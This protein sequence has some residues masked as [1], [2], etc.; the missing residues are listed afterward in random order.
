MRRIWRPSRLNWV[1]L[2]Y[3]WVNQLFLVKSKQKLLC[4]TKNPMNDQIIWQQYIQQV[5]SLSR[6][7]RVSKICKEACFMRV[8]EVGQY[9]V[10]KDTGDFRQFRSVA[11]REYT[12]TTR[13]SSFST[14]RMDSRKYEDWTFIGSHD[15][16]SALQIWNWNSNWVREPRQFSFLGQNFLWNG[17]IRDRFYSR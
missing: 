17:Q 11:C 6:E 12:L 9:F 1:N 7:N 10:T 15:Q 8:I 16:F 2:W 5:E 3:W 13:R 4:T 14:K